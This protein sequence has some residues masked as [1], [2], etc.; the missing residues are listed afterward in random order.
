MGGLSFLEAKVV[1]PATKRDYLKRYIAFI[2]FCTVRQLP[3]GSRESDEIAMLEWADHLFSEGAPASDGTKSLA[4]SLHFHPER[5]R[6]AGA[7]MPRVS[8]AMQAWGRLRP[9]NGRLPPAYRIV[10][11]ITVA[12]VLLSRRDMAVATLVALSAYLRP[13]EL[14]GLRC[15]DLV[16]PLPMFGTSFGRWS[17]L[18]GPYATRKPTKTGIYDDSVI[19][20]H[21]S[22]NWLGDEISLLLA[23]RGP[24]EPMWTFDSSDYLRMFKQAVAMLGLEHLGLVPYS[25][26]HAGPSWD[27]LTGRRPQREIQRRGRWKSTASVVRYERASR[28]LAALHEVPGPMLRYLSL[29]EQHLASYV[30]GDVPP[31]RPPTT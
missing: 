26:R 17:L 10:C 31:P 6:L 8:R 16:R 5:G 28:V 18:L 27:A 1:Q 24:D 22:L 14:F 15:R 2:Q 23:N 4:A 3:R 13:G 9:A 29:C 7:C 20:D 11:G 25:L 19:L 21:E 30:K 12:L